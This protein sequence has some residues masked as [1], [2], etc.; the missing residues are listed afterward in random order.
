[1]VDMHG[2][3]A[4]ADGAESQRLDTGGPSGPRVEGMGRGKGRGMGRVSLPWH[5][6]ESRQGWRASGGKGQSVTVV[7]RATGQAVNREIAASVQMVQ[8]ITGLPGQGVHQCG[9]GDS[10]PQNLH[11]CSASDLRRQH[12][13]GLSPVLEPRILRLSQVQG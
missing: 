10:S 3:R 2:I 9:N 7:A 5:R 12:L 13:K 4:G 1:M 8:A 11:L 6:R